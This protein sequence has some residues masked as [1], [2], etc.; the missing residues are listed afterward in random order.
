MNTDKRSSRKSLLIPALTTGVALSLGGL[1]LATAAAESAPNI[2]AALRTA[3]AATVVQQQ[4]KAEKAATDAYRGKL[5]GCLASHGAKVE[6]LADGGY[7]V[8]LSREQANDDGQALRT[9][10]AECQ[11][12]LGFAAAAPPNAN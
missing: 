1:A 3:P 9:L 10:Q 12:E 6:K 7:S 8:F 5:M 11:R 4:P 2:G